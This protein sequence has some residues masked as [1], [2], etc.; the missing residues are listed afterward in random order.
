[1]KTN[2]HVLASRCDTWTLL[3]HLKPTLLWSFVLLSLV[4]LSSLRHLNLIF[5]IHRLKH[6]ILI[7]QR[8]LPHNLQCPPPEFN[9]RRLRYPPLSNTSAFA[10]A[11]PC[12]PYVTTISHFVAVGPSGG[13]LGFLCL[14]LC[15]PP[16]LKF[17]SKLL[18]PLPTSSATVMNLPRYYC[19]Y[20]KASGRE[21]WC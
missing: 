6:L 14:L 12:L 16:L 20:C 17:A 15:H 2:R 11:P 21:N 8:N 9:P 19:F 10:P 3:R 5:S 1:M 7:L 18:L 13:P 4:L